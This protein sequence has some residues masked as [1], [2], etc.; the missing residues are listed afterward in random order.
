MDREHVQVTCSAPWLLRFGTTMYRLVAVVLL[1]PVACYPLGV[2]AVSLNGEPLPRTV[3]LTRFYP[4]LLVV[5]IGTLVVAGG[6]R[7]GRHWARPAAA[8]WF[9]LLPLLMLLASV[10]MGVPPL[11]ALLPTLL[12]GFSGAAASLAYLYYNPGVAR[13]FEC[14]AA[15]DA[16]APARAQRSAELDAWLRKPN[17]PR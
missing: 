9:V 13:Y 12:A 14:V 17:R 6:L 11:S 3:V 15:Q 2:G 5:G 8:L 4:L 10:G 16:A 1:L 7:R